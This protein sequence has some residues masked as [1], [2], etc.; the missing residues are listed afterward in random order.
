MAPSPHVSYLGGDNLAQSFHVDAL[1]E[2]LADRHDPLDL[3]YHRDLYELSTDE[4]LREDHDIL[5]L[6]GI[7][8]VLRGEVEL[9]R[10]CLPDD[11]AYFLLTRGI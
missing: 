6:R 9:I 7:F 4:F 3:R 1:P 2:R 5:P 11:E 10:A 8:L